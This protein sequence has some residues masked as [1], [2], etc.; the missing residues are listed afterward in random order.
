M[1]KKNSN[2]ETDNSDT[3]HSDSDIKDPKRQ[4]RAE[5]DFIPLISFLLNNRYDEDGINIEK[6]DITEEQIDICPGLYCDHNIN[7]INIPNISDRFNN[8]DEKYK[9][10]INDLIE[11]G[12]CY[13]CKCQKTYKNIS[14]E[15]LAKLRE[16]FVKL[17]SMVGMKEIK[18]DLIEQIIYFLLDLEPNPQ[19][20]LHTILEG[21]PGVGK[22]HII[23]ILADIYL[24][25]GYLTKKIIKKVKLNDLKGK[26]V[27]HTAPLTQK[28]IDD[29]MGGILVID[30]AYSL[31][32]KNNLDSF[33]KEIIDTLNRNLTEN[34]GKFIC[35]I[36]GYGKELEETL[37]AHNQGLK[38]RFRFKF[39]IDS[40][41][42]KELSQIF[43]MKVNKDNWCFDPDI[44]LDKK[45]KFFSKNH[46]SFKY[47]GRDMETLL[48]HT[49]VAHSNRIFFLPSYHKNKI[50]FEDIQSG[51]NRFNLHND[52]DEEL[53]PSIR[54]L[55]S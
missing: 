50:T 24:N 7:S 18:K 22:S 1:P 44:N 35:I 36:A 21:P 17:N 2:I 34:A 40:Y 14:L 19:E 48:F 28:A 5:T 6:N 31:G 53:P 47:F 3:Y 4:K 8:Y 46:K 45:E 42:S 26:Y 9:I 23:D 39:T 10:T 55:Y 29:A 15:I 52:K 38:S 49:K 37:F 20:M 12:E 16:P 51:Y 13:H 41:S 32:S 43:T 25:M 33:S 27:G 54:H 11:L 30:E